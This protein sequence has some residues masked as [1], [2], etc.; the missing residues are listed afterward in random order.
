[1][2]VVDASLAAKWNFREDNSDRARHRYQFCVQE[3][4]PIV[5]PPL[6][7]SDLLCHATMY[8]N[9]LLHSF[10]FESTS[11]NLLIYTYG[12]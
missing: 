4:L 3:Q 9:C 8:G 7:L 2:I 6:I 5:A 12:R 11:W 10:H 1:M